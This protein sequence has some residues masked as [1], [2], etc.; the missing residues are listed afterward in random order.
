MVAPRPEI[1]SKLTIR[2]RVNARHLRDE[3]HSWL[4]AKRSSRIREA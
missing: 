4:T 2:S 1:K 3:I